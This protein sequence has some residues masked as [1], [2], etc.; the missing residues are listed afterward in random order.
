LPNRSSVVGTF[1]E[2]HHLTCMDITW[3]VHAKFDIFKDG[4]LLHEDIP[5]WLLKGQLLPHG[6]SGDDFDKLRR[7]LAA[8]GSA[9]IRLPEVRDMFKQ[10]G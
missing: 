8:T 4:E 9:V 7:Q 2:L 5:Q 6:I 1:F 10:A 3:E